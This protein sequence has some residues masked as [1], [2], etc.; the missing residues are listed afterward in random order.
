M[1]MH[2]ACNWGVLGSVQRCI[3]C[4]TSVCFTP[5]FCHLINH[6]SSCSVCVCVVCV[7]VCVCSLVVAKEMRLSLRAPCLASADLGHHTGPRHPD[8]VEN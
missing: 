4:P 6:L 1:C 2:I 8:K 7:C 5:Q 3:Q